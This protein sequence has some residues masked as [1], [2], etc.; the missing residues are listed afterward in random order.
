MGQEAAGRHVVQKLKKK[1][2]FGKNTQK[3]RIPEQVIR[4]LWR[5]IQILPWTALAQPPPQGFLER[6][7]EIRWA[8]PTPTPNSWEIARQDAPEA[9]SAS[10][11]FWLTNIGGRPR[12]FVRKLEEMRAAHAPW[13]HAPPHP[14]TERIF[15]G[16]VRLDARRI[17]AVLPQ[18]GSFSQGA[19]K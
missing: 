4:S 9:R 18:W 7:W 15:C 19:N 1:T 5:K 17:T 2:G 14:L 12:R 16:R 6:C 11:R 8:V 13:R 10:S 3:R